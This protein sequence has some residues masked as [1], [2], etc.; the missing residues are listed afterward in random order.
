GDYQ[1]PL[2]ARA[3][4]D[5]LSGSQD[6]VNARLA[7]DR[8]GLVQAMTNGEKVVPGAYANQSPALN[9]DGLEKVVGMTAGYQ[10]PDAAATK[11][12]VFKTAGQVLDKESSDATQPMVEQM[13]KL[14]LSDPQGITKALYG[15][16]V[17]GKRRSEVPGQDVTGD[18]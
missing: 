17:D 18:T 3:S 16:N 2:Y 1:T 4:L 12:E 9:S 15:D 10:G 14:F 11:A 7:S 6:L 5:A 8:A 13:S